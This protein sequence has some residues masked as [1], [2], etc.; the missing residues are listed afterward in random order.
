MDFR[1][2]Q[3]AAPRSWTDFEDLCHAIFRAEWSDPLAQKNGRSGQPQHGVD[4]FGSPNAI[5][6]VCHGVQCKGK[7][8]TYGRKPTLTELTREIAKADSFTP[9]LEHWVFATSAGKDEKLQQAARELSAARKSKGLFTV[10]VLGWEDIQ[11]LLSRHPNVVQD[12]YPEHAFDIP[13]LL[14]SLRELPS[15]DDVRELLKHVRHFIEVE[16]SPSNAAAHDAIWVRQTI[17]DSRDLGPALLGRS[18]GPA[19]ASACPRLQEV[20]IVISQLRRGFFARLVGGPGSGKSVCAYQVARELSASAWNVFR[21]RDNAI[22]EPFPLPTEGP[23]L[24]LIDD[25]HLMAGTTLQ[26]VEEM[27]SQRR[28]VLSILNSVEN[29]RIDRGAV[30]LDSKRAV[31]TIAAALR[32]DADR[33]LATVRRIDDEV[34]ASFLQVP[35][36][37]RI[38]HAE[39]VSDRPWQFCFVLGGGWRRSKEAADA[40]RVRGADLVLAAASIKQLA[41]R[42]APLNPSALKA[43]CVQQGITA[44]HTDT[45]IAWLAAQRLIL[46]EVDCRCPHQRFA[47]VA[48]GHILAG[49]DDTGRGIIGGMLQATVGDPAFPLA[50]LRILLHEVRF[51]GDYRQWTHLISP[52]PLEPLVARCWVAETPEDR[53]SAAFILAELDSYLPDRGS[54][55]TICL[56]A[57]FFCLACP[58][59][60]LDNN[61]FS[62]LEGHACPRRRRQSGTRN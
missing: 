42:D 55:A 56:S 25:A 45:A 18:L 40:A 52:Q 4:V 46:S 15:G 16:N 26:R 47:A 50:G 62:G 8:H 58:T 7:D 54:C 49:Q 17:S 1:S 43:F 57:I 44:N 61:A 24:L 38:D 2:K 21:L 9:P 51:R 29:G 6:D 31:K 35:L 48:L 12:F 34:G 36:Q 53:A 20:D 41:S 13:G 11:F 10:T 30:L 28:F 59:M 37:Q 14:G 32:A 60:T 39:N 3:I 22:Q 23:A 33:T 5:R 27:A 19:N